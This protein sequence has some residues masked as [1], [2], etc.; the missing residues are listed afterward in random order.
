MIGVQLS[1][2]LQGHLR[3]DG[4]SRMHFQGFNCSLS[5]ASASDA[6]LESPS[7]CAFLCSKRSRIPST[8]VFSLQST[9]GSCCL[10]YVVERDKKNRRDKLEPLSCGH[11]L[12]LSSVVLKR[13]LFSLVTTLILRNLCPTPRLKGTKLVGYRYHF[14][15]YVPFLGDPEVSDRRLLHVHI[16]FQ[17]PFQYRHN[18]LSGKGACQFDSKTSV[19]Q[20]W[21]G[22]I[23]FA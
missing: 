10:S 4:I 2:V 21:R 20:G 5:L 14:R 23:L 11:D 16:D 17:L 3:N 13:R 7:R 15:P 12:Y 22:G 9:H 8:P 18:C 19:L 1:K 6:S